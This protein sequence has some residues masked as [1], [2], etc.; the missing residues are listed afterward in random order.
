MK[1]MKLTKK[2]KTELDKVVKFFLEATEPIEDSHLRAMVDVKIM[3]RIG[4]FAERLTK[5]F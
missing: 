5:E 4:C 3:S 1:L 2:Q